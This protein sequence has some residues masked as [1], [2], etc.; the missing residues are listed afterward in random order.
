MGTWFGSAV[1]TVTE[2][3]MLPLDW[4]PP[5]IALLIVTVLTGGVALWVVK[6]TTNQKALVRARQRMTAA[7]YEMRL[8]LDEPLRVARAQVR[9][10]LW[11]FLYTGQTL[12]A[13]LVL[14]VPLGL[15]YLHLELRHGYAPF[16]PD[17]RVMLGVQLVDGTA[18]K[19]AK[20]ELD[21][22]LQ[23]DLGPIVAEREG[24]LY[25]RLKVASEGR[26]VARV[27]VGE[28]TFEKQIVASENG[29]VSV[30]RAPGISNAW[31]ASSE[32]ALDPDGLVQRM[33]LNHGPRE[34]TWLGVPWWAIWLVGS[35]I[36]ALML[37]KPLRAEI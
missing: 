19:D 18:A 33:W 34:D 30:E 22:G 2:W 28:A 5:S 16:A 24:R 8:F 7:I 35:G 31:A 15:V 32:A 37:K 11:S 26:H 21:E 9:L 4:L 36:A 14:T 1:H 3:L 25:Y 29:P 13:L 27:S 23:L 10:V 12:P 17:N 20:L 6:L